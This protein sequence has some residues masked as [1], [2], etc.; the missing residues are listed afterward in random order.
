MRSYRLATFAVLLTTASAGVALAQGMPVGN[1]EAMA[2]VRES[3]Q[4]DALLRSSP[5]FRQKRMQI[6]CGPITDAQLHASCVASFQ[7]Y[8]PTPPIKRRRAPPP[9]Q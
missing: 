7:N 6:E 4:F 1:P 2:N 5:A 3:K 9:A 8:G